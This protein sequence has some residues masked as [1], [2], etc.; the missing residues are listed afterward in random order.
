[1]DRLSDAAA[2][3][4]ERAQDEAAGMGHDYLG[5]EHVLAALARGAR[6]DAATEALK[7]CGASPERV[8]DGLLFMLGRG[9]R[10][11]GGRPRHLTPRLKRAIEVADAEAGGSE[12]EPGHLLLGLLHERDGVAAKIL[13]ALECDESLRGR[14]RH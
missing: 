4:L 7:T 14:L 5:T 9:G 6:D 8:R 12:I 13:A 2:Q 3:A 10:P 1:L 11:G